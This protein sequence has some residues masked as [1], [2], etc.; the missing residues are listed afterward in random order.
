MTGRELYQD[1]I[2]NLLKV[3]ADIDKYPEHYKIYPQ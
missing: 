3:E 2:N 1:E